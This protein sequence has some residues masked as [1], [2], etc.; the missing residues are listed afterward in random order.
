MGKGGHHN[1]LTS[2]D[3]LP[4]QSSGALCAILGKELS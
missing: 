3:T 2:Y 4:V 1:R